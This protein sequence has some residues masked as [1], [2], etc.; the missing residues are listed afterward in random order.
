MRG[1][2]L[3]DATP[4][5]GGKKAD[6]D[7]AAVFERIRASHDFVTK[8]EGDGA[9][10]VKD[11]PEEECEVI[12]DAEIAEATKDVIFNEVKTKAEPTR[13]IQKTTLRQVLHGREAVDACMS[14]LWKLLLYLRGP[15]QG[16]DFEILPKPL[17]T[18]DVIA[19][20]KKRKWHNVAMQAITRMDLANKEPTFRTSRVISW[21]NHVEK[22]RQEIAPTLPEVLQIDRGDVLA[23]KAGDKWHVGLVLS[24][25]RY[26]TNR[27]GNSQ[28]SPHAL[29]LG[30]VR[31]AR[32]VRAPALVSGV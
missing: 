20:K 30:S 29:P 18:R 26:Y 9:E 17:A 27:S 28:L 22:N 31:Y 12:E 6:A 13:A 21:C 24:I 1:L 32:V 4:G 8:S 14:D 5:A 19:G 10:L 7:A 16:C 15:D 2:K 11:L 23:V 3:F 25:W